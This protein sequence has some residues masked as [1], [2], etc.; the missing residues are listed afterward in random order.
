[1]TTAT[2]IRK[3]QHHVTFESVKGLR[4]EGYIRDST[5]DQKNGFG[6]D[7]QRPVKS[8]P[9]LCWLHTI[10]RLKLWC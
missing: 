8:V 10:R 7:I 6:P 9:E 1:M 5:V 2:L 4:A 3:T